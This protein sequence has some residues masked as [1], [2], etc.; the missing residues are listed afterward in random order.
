M[1]LRSTNGTE[2]KNSNQSDLVGMESVSNPATLYK[3][4]RLDVERYFQFLEDYF[5]LMAELGVSES[6]ERI[7]IKNPKF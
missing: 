1:P 7:V 2:L 6:R 4:G 5:K 3:D